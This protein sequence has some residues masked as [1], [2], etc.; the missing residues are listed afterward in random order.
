MATDFSSASY[1][2]VCFSAWKEDRKDYACAIFFQ[3]CVQKPCLKYVEMD[4][5][6]HLLGCRQN[7]LMGLQRCAHVREFMLQK[8]YFGVISKQNHGPRGNIKLLLTG[9]LLFFFLPLNYL[10]FFMQIQGQQL[11]PRCKAAILLEQW[12]CWGE[13]DGSECSPNG[14]LPLVRRQ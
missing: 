13:T 1:I 11:L 8:S 12:Q 3:P 10:T 2:I 7:K 5:N 14:L 9:Q 4:L 6:S